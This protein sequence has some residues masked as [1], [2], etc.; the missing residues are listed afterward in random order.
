MRGDRPGARA[1]REASAEAP[2]RARGSTRGRDE[3]RPAPPGSPAC[4]GIDP[5]SRSPS[6]R[7]RWLPRVRGDRP[8]TVTE[9]ANAEEA[10]P[11]ARGSTRRGIDGVEEPVGSPACAGI[12]RSP[13]SSRPSARG[14]P[15]VRGDRPCALSRLSPRASAPPR[16]RGSTLVHIGLHLR[17]DGSPACAGIDPCSSGP[18]DFGGGLPRVRGDRPVDKVLGRLAR[19]A[20]PRARGST[21]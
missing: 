20:P 18:F 13:R 21:R 12:D 16:A 15:R 11:R 1:Y 19:S 6:T 2:P 10:P 17:P 9:L 14:L 3:D 5:R 8:T 4:A 7:R